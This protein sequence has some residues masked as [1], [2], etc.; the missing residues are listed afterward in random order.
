MD[1]LLYNLI[2]NRTFSAA[3]IISTV[4][5]NHDGEFLATGD[6]GGRVVIFQKDLGVCMLYLSCAL[7]LIYCKHKA[8]E[9][10]YQT[11][12]ISGGLHF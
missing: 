10:F 5:F 8:F 3:D 1:V 11:V 12:P 9:L 2:C 7:F 6:K 4:Q